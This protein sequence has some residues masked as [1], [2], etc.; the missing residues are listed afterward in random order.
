MAALARGRARFES[1]AG[2]RIEAH[3]ALGSDAHISG[4]TH[5][6]AFVARAQIVR[7]T[8]TFTGASAA[9]EALLSAGI[10]LR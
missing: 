6:P 3:L 9:T 5:A 4:A 7:A 10:D 2:A 1:E 8:L